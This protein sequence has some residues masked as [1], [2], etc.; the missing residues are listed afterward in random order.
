MPDEGVR[1]YILF[2]H[3]DQGMRLHDLLDENGIENRIAPAP[4]EIQGKLGCGMSLLIRPE[5]IEA[6][7]ECIRRNQADHHD[8][9]ALKGQLK[10][11]RDKYC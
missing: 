1:Y 4:R 3:Y 9:V 6:T 7:R 11:R 5:H 10:S 2:V 8:I